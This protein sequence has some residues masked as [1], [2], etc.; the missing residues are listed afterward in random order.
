MYD[1]L[2]EEPSTP[3]VKI[4]MNW[5]NDDKGRNILYKKNGEERYPDFKLYKM[6]ARTVHKHV[7]LDVLN[8][9]YFNK[10]IVSKNVIKMEKVNISMDL[11]NIPCYTSLPC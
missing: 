9:D 1:Y 11:D 4:M 3:I 2:T 10:F 6:I 5:C 8:N 7:P